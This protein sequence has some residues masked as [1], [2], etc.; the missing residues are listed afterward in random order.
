MKRKQIACRKHKKTRHS[1]NLNYIFSFFLSLVCKVKVD[2]GFVID[3]S[4]SI[5]MYGKGN[6]QKVKDF[7]K[8]VVQGFDVS[9]VGTHMGVVLYSTTPEVVFGFKKYYDKA[10]VLADI[11]SMYYPGRSTRTGMALGLARTGLFEKGSRPGVPHMLLVL[12]DGQSQDSVTEPAQKLRDFGVTVFS[13]GIGTNYNK[14]DLNNMASD[15]DSEHVFTADFNDMQT[16]VQKI[17]GSVCKSKAVVSC[18][19]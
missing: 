1:F 17:K 3:G 6:Y 13:I 19:N 9:L 5:E 15:P 11:D 2:L 7:V 12:T 18:Y 14:Q 10:S 4:G 16:L 8:S